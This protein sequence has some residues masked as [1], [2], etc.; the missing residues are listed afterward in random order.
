M[1]EAQ[2]Q[3]YKDIHNEKILDFMRAKSIPFTPETHNLFTE[4]VVENLPP[5]VFKASSATSIFRI[6]DINDLSSSEVAALFEQ[7][8][9]TFQRRLI[10]KQK[11]QR[12]FEKSKRTKKDQMI[13]ENRKMSEFFSAPKKRN[14]KK[15]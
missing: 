6:I 4:C 13:A 2:Q 3:L 10:D 9:K 14:T 8:L 7:S 12:A 5:T 15:Q 1:E 11:R